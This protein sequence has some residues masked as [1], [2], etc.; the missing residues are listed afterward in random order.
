M[1][2]QDRWVYSC[3][4]NKNHTQEAVLLR[5]LWRLLWHHGP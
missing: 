2:C 3:K 5:S 1:K 4:N